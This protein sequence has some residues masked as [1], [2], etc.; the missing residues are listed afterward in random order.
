VNRRYYISPAKKAVLFVPEPL[1]MGSPAARLAQQWHDEF[2]ATID[3][4]VPEGRP[5]PV[6]PWSDVRGGWKKGWQGY[7]LQGTKAPSKYWTAWPP[8]AAP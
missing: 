4:F 8:K 1:R 5:C 2:G 3:L 6:F 7:H